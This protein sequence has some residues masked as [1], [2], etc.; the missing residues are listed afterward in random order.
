MDSSITSVGQIHISVSDLDRSVAWYRDVLGLDFLFSVPGQPMAFLQ[1]GETRIYLGVPE[2]EHFRSR[3]ILYFA[4]DAIDEAVSAIE[5]RGGVFSAQPHV[6]HRDQA[7]EMWLAS[8]AD[9][10]NLPVLI[11]ETRAI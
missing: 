4:V 7:S 5:A 6:V 10:D 9:P 11:M 1:C 2:V 3:P 8:L